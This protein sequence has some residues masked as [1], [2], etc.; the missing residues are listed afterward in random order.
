[1]TQPITDYAAFLGEAKQAIENLDRLKKNRNQLDS[2][3]KQLE[4]QLEAEKRQWM[5][6]L[7]LPLK[8]GG[9]KSQAAMIRKFQE[10]RND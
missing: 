9:K 5:K 10:D 8:N 2:E 1:M 6:R 7:P 3:E 4:R